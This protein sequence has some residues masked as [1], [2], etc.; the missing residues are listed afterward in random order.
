M[1]SLNPRVVLKALAVAVLVLGPFASQPAAATPPG[2]AL[3]ADSNQGG[4]SD[5]FPNPTV[6][7]ARSAT[8]NWGL[9]P[10][11]ARTDSRA[12]P[13]NTLVLN[14]FDNVSFLAVLDQVDVKRNGV[15]WVGHISDS[16][17]STVTLVTEGNVMAGSIVMPGAT[18]SIR[19]TQNDVHT[20]YEI[21]QA[22]FPPEAKPLVAGDA[23]PPVAPSGAAPADSGG[24]ID[25]MV[26][27]TSAARAIQGSTAAMTALINLG[28]SETNTSYQNSG[29][30]QRL[31]LVH[32]VEVAYVESGSFYTDL[33]NLTNGSGAL[34]NVPAYRNTYGADLVS[35][36][37]GYSSP[38]L[39]GLGWMPYTV[40]SSN[41]IYGFTVVD[42]SCVSPNYSFG[43]ELG[44]NMH[45][46]HD[47]YGD[48]GGGATP[49]TT[50]YTYMHGY[51]NTTA[52]WRTMMAYNDLCAA[53]GF[54]CTRLLYWSNPGITY[55]GAA[56]GVPAGTN[57]TCMRNV[58]NPPCDAD[59]HLV[60]N[61]TAYTI[62]NYRQSVAAPAYA[63][64][65]PAIVKS[66]A[67]GL[68][69]TPGYWLSD[70]GAHEFYVTPDSAFVRNHA[71]RLNVTG[72]GTYKIT[73]TASEAISANQYSFSGTFYASGTFNSATTATVTD[74]LSSFNIIGC[75]IISGG[76]W[77]RTYTWQNSTQPDLAAHVVGREISNSIPADSAV[78]VTSLH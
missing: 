34:A 44:H 19:S 6:M 70:N 22:A 63:A 45:A 33:D 17:A 27:Y 30:T 61:N 5:Q 36:F 50:P 65:L 71:V 47:W 75:G 53:L 29:I 24:T 18:Y 16:P 8:I 76:P 35:M 67:A 69:P 9:L 15:V 26:V 55:S 73:H 77:T 74:G 46:S 57:T 58:S 78:E 41:A 13:G 10:T 4:A 64:Y 40:S 7:R 60:L 14:L 21:N 31:R 66:M 52:H 51:I 32:S 54:N 12:L 62:A 42:Q 48:A 28:I 1:N 68:I 2:P 43:H 49:P 56:M 20:I 3:F 37:V 59:N 23:S 38:S 11:G 39:C 72:C 25:V